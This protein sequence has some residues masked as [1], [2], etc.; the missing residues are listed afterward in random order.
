MK[1]KCKACGYVMEEGKIKDV[2]PAC[3]LPKTVFEPYD[4]KLSPKRRLIME[5]DLH[6]IIVH[7]PQA[8]AVFIPPCIV[9]S[10]FVPAPFNGDLLST[11]KILALVLPLSV[12]ASLVTGMIDGKNRFKKLNTPAQKFKIVLGSVLFILTLGIFYVVLF[13]GFSVTGQILI[14][15]LCTCAIACQVLLAR[16]GIKLMFSH[17]KG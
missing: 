2:C 12:L 13:V 8:F 4:D 9:V 7:F 15:A 11:V 1:M 3:G 16:T 6:A 5:L 10:Y 17:L 14:I